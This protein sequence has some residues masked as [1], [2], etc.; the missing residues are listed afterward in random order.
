MAVATP[1]CFVSQTLQ[2]RRVAFANK[3][4]EQGSVRDASDYCILF[5]KVGG[6]GISR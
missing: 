6:F 4:I 5:A 3:G 1:F 2:K